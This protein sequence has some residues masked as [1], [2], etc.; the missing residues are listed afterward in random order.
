V[1]ATGVAV[2]QFS[3]ATPSVTEWLSAIGEL[4]LGV[5]AAGFGGYQYWR[6]GY[7]PKVS[8]LIDG[9]RRGIS[10]RVENRGRAAGIV[11]NVNATYQ[12]GKDVVVET[13]TYSDGAH[14]QR[15]QQWQ[16]IVLAP[17]G[18]LLT[19]LRRVDKDPD[20]S[21]KAFATT[22][23]V[24]VALGKANPNS[25]TPDPDAGTD[26]TGLSGYVLEPKPGG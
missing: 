13:V 4:L 14:P 20:G 3:A 8:A 24:T 9:S 19:Y 25:V 17:G 2:P 23:K 7:R 18:F 11:E 5:F 26:Y 21:A 6:S 16:P 22:V 10:V 1:L 15:P 12:L